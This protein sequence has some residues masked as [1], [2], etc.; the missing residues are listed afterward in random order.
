MNQI[1]LASIPLAAIGLL[2]ILLRFVIVKIGSLR[3]YVIHSLKNFM[4]LEFL[5]LFQIYFCYMTVSK[6]DTENYEQ[7]QLLKLRS[8]IFYTSMWVKSFRKFWFL[9]S[10]FESNRFVLFIKYTLLCCFILNDFWRPPSKLKK[11]YLY[12][13]FYKVYKNK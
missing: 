7:N 9:I 10:Y 12:L 4:G 13:F 6:L 11:I 2:R 3:K 1:N 8:I 5:V